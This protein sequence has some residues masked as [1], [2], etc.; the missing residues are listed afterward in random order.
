V[1]D[2]PDIVVENP[3]NARQFQTLLYDRSDMLGDQ[4]SWYCSFRRGNA[5]YEK[6]TSEIVSVFCRRCFGGGLIFELCIIDFT[7]HWAPRSCR[8]NWCCRGLYCFRRASNS[9]RASY[10]YGH[11]FVCPS[12]RQSVRVSVCLA[13]AWIVTKRDNR[14][15][16]CQ[17]HTIE[18]CF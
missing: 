8:P 5:C 9:V 7:V 3:Q 17:H 11:L 18:Q 6:P 15:P 10:R 13:N 4:V 12:V 16:I 14:L 1:T 2:G